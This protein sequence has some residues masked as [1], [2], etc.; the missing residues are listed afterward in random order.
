VDDAFSYEHIEYRMA[1]LLLVLLGFGVV[2]Q[3]LFVLVRNEVAVCSVQEEQ[4]EHKV[5]Q[6]RVFLLQFVQVRQSLCSLPLHQ[7]DHSLRKELV[8]LHRWG[9]E[10][11]K[12]ASADVVVGT[13]EVSISDLKFGDFN[14]GY[15]KAG[16]RGIVFDALL[17][18][19]DGLTDLV[20][21][22]LKHSS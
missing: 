15:G 13:V 6:L 22:C 1:I 8:D 3:T 5:V 7:K 16:L 17:K 14:Q 10:F 9:F 11:Q 12:L 20:L 18:R 19:K 4:F 21:L 2:L